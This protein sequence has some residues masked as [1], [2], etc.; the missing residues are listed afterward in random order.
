MMEYQIEA[1]T[2]RCTATGRELKPGDKFYS[3]LVDEDG[4]FQRRDYAGEAWQGPS[5]DAFCFWCGRIPALADGQRPPIDEDLLFDCFHRLEGE[6]DPAHVNF[7]Y[8]VALLLMRR[9]RLK[10]EAAGTEGDR[11]VLT[12]R[13][14]RS[15]N[16]YRVINPA[17]TEVE[18]TAVQDEVFRVLG[19]Q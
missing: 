11:D 19:W 6:L 12:L 18:M 10:F 4:K 16:H 13:C 1:N 8:V 17:L 14:V 2:R 5:Q 9:K 15:R 3:V 7:R